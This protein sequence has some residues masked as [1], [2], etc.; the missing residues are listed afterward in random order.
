MTF[1]P[2]NVILDTVDAVL[3][4]ALKKFQIRAEHVRSFYEYGK[5]QI[6]CSEKF[7]SKFSYGYVEG[8]FRNPL[9]RIRQRTK[10]NPFNEQRS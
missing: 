6:F 4:K 10:K 9:K 1:F 7:L 5:I 3:T 2:Q 8:N